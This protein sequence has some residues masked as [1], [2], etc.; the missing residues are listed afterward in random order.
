MECRRCVRAVT[1]RLRDL[2]GVQTVQADAR[3]A[4][5]VLVGAVEVRAALAAL[6]DAGHPDAVV[7]WPDAVETSP[8]G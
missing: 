8:A 2:A 6:A 1:A 5:V 3:T 7:V 4:T